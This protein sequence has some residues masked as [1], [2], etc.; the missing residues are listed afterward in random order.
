MD[1]YD[2]SWKYCPDTGRSTG[3]YILLY[4]GKIIDH[5]TYITGTIVQSSA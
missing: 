1:L 4:Q 3:S 5:D 2:S